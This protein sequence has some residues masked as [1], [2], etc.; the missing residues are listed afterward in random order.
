MLGFAKPT[1]YIR[2]N[3]ENYRDNNYRGG[4]EN[5]SNGYYGGKNRNNYSNASTGADSPT[6]NAGDDKQGYQNGGQEDY[7]RGY[8]RKI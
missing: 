6:N 1:P 3:R 7:N 8:K 5:N 4:Y 2:K